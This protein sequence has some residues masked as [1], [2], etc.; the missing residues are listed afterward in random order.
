MSK[1]IIEG[2]MPLHGSITPK[3]AKN[4]ALQVIAATLLTEKEVDID[5][6]PEILD[7]HNLIDLMTRIGVRVTKR[8]PGSYTFCAEAL[9][10]Q[11]VNSRRLR[12]A[13][14]RTARFGSARGPAAGPTRQGLFPEARR[15]QDRTP[16]G[17]HA[18]PG[19][20]QPRR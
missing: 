5:N 14:R 20:A 9:D 3:G 17:R 15:R 8:G 13:L 4:E 19:N 16:Q 10:A 11:F 1:F 18:Y 6:I 7:V 12:Q 2:G